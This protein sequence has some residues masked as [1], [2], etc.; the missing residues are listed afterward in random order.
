MRPNFF[1][2]TPDILHEY[3]QH[4]GR[5]GRSRCGC[6]S[7]RRCRPAT[8]STADSSCASTWRC[9]RA[10]RSTSIRRST[11]FASAT[12]MR[13]EHIKELIAPVERDPART[14]RRC[15]GTTRCSSI[16]T[17]NPDLLA[18]SKTDDQAIVVFVVV[19]TDPHHM[20]HGWVRMRGDA[21]SS[22]QPYV[23]V[24]LLDEARYTLARRVELRPARSRRAGRTRFRGRIAVTTTSTPRSSYGRLVSRR[25][26][27]RSARPRLLRQQR[28]RHRRLRRPE[29]AAALPSGSRRHLPL[30]AAVLSLAASRRRLRHRRL[31]VDQSDLRHRWTTSSGFSTRRTRAT[32]AC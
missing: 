3:L 18:F 22:G 4:G 30:A 1:A 25:P 12:G 2:N 13:R 19:N 16:E 20:Q 7:R 28:R 21:A 15:S 23:V 8:A 27:L 5:A 29:P 17:D 24:D 6:C 9:A 31:H 10:P 26:H 32:S 14:T 11:R